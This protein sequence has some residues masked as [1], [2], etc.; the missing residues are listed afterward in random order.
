MSAPAVHGMNRQHVYDVL[1]HGFP[2]GRSLL[3]GDFGQ[4]SPVARF[5]SETRSIFHRLAD[6][7][8]LDA[9]LF[10]CYWILPPCYAVFQKS[11]VNI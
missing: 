8:F 6:D 3:S 4:V 11:T 7:L 9:K 10:S 1:L 5:S 2:D